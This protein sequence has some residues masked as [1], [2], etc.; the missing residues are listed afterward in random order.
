MLI[1]RRPVE[2]FVI[3]DVICDENTYVCKFPQLEGYKLVIRL[4]DAQG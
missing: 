2:N 4:S 1:P 3:C